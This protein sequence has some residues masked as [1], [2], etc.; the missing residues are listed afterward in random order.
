MIVARRGTA[1]ERG[2]VDGK[3]GAQ[4][5]ATAMLARRAVHP[6]THSSLPVPVRLGLEHSPFAK[7]AGLA[8]SESRNRCQGRR[9]RNWTGGKP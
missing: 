8:K 9:L 6:E 1:N 5:E 7:K 2:N 4:V 3:A